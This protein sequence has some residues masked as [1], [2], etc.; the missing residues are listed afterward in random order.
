MENKKKL[1]GTDIYINNDLPKKIAEERRIRRIDAQNAG[2][3]ELQNINKRSR[4]RESSADT[5]EKPAY[6]TARQQLEEQGTI[7]FFSPLHTTH[8]GIKSVL[9]TEII[10][11]NK[12]IS[13]VN[14]FDNIFNNKSNITVMSSTQLSL[15]FWNING[16]G[17]LFNVDQE[18]I[19]RILAMDVVCLCET[20][21]CQL[22]H[23]CF[24]ST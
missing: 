20:W 10:Q 9:P 24:Q 11:I 17:N 7:N 5:P 15:I 2:K 21:Q 19:E 23:W 6:M 13:R 8:E 16:V 12:K 4:N 22:D 18:N 3:R 1:Q 14:N